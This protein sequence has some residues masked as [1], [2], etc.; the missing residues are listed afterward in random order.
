M[1]KVKLFL[2]AVLFMIL[3]TLPSAA[4]DYSLGVRTT[5]MQGCLL[6]KPPD[7]ENKTEV[8]LKIKRCMCMLD[9]FQ[10][11]Y[12]EAQFVDMF[13]HAE[14]QY[15]WQKRELDDFVEETMPGCL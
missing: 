13:S 15:S 14:K 7:F 1:V 12:S 11:R 6:D 2:A 8:F 10:G 4:Y 3:F 9:K 5:F